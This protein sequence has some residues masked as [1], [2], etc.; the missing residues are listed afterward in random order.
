M[1]GGTCSG[2]GH[3][4][5]ER[6]KFVVDPV[7]QL[8]QQNAFKRDFLFRG[9]LRHGVL[10]FKAFLVLRSLTEHPALTDGASADS[11]E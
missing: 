2:P 7:D 9:S 3:G 10:L 8:V 5:D 4:A 11:S 1:I 6:R